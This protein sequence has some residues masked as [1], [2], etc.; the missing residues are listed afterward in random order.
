MKKSLHEIITTNHVL[1]KKTQLPDHELIKGE[2][3]NK[4]IVYTWGNLC[5][6]ERKIIIFFK[7]HIIW[8]HC[9]IKLNVWSIFI[10][11]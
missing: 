9:L 6:N 5:V 4:K 2:E 7:C 11:L 8:A 3:V 1:K 10:L